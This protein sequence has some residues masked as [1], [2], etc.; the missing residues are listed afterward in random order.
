MGIIVLSSLVMSKG[1]MDGAAPKLVPKRAPTAYLS[2]RILGTSTAVK[3]VL[4]VPYVLNVA[5]I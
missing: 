2:R 3:P 1:K 5:A 4:A